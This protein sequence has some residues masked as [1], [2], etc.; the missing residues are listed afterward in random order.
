M[1]NVVCWATYLLP[2]PGII[3]Q[4]E[5]NPTALREHTQG[6]KPTRAD[7]PLGAFLPRPLKAEIVI[8][9]HLLV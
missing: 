9:H 3:T 4:I 8:D 6:M 1:Q 5:P 2:L 7:L